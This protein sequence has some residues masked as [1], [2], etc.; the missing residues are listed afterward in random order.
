MLFAYLEEQVEP[1]AV[2]RRSGQ[3]D[4][5]WQTQLEV[6]LCWLEQPSAAKQSL[7]V[8]EVQFP[9]CC[10]LSSIESLVPPQLLA[11]GQTLLADWLN[12]Q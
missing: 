11:P 9:G 8:W 4:I 7:Q 2:S 12:L 1:L 3:A 6:F 5:E 10:G